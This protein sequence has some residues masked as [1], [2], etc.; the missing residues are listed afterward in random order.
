MPGATL[1]TRWIGPRSGV[2][3]LA[4]KVGFWTLLT[5]GFYRFWG[6]TRMR[7][8]FWSSVQPGGHPLEYVGHPL[9]KLLGFLIAVVIMAFYLGIV[10]LIL[11]FASYSLFS[12][13][14]GGYVASFIGVVPVIFYAQYRARRYVLARTRWRG[15]RFG[16]E[17][18]A[19]AYAWCA[20]KHWLA[21][22]LTVG[23]W[24]PR[25][26]LALETF[27]TNRTHFG[28]ARFQQSGYWGDLYRGFV[29]VIFGAFL[30]AIGIG[31]ISLGE[32]RLWPLPIAGLVWFVYG[33]LHYQAY[34]TRYLTNHKI[35]LV[36]GKAVL[37]KSDLR[38]PRVVG[39]YSLG[40]TIASG[41]AFL[42]L[43]ALSIAIAVFFVT[44]EVDDVDF[45]TT[46]VLEDVPSVVVAAFGVI[47][48]LGMMLMWNVLTYTFVTMPLWRHL[49]E[50]FSL[51]K[52]GALENVG[53]RARDEF[54]EA[55]GFAEALDVG[56]AL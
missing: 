50:T 48:Y 34:A 56:A 18:G 53:Q 19:W 5:L 38:I 40:Y 33:T 17:P 3:W 44:M 41:L 46:S 8:W 55:E 54:G 7:R 24:W 51:N 43:I 11:M 26:T 1:E 13:P 25:K 6:K 29:H 12:A 2:F 14:T 52:A 45:M 47:F 42:P 22:I 27:K 9:E 21:T 31:L 30:T 36:E 37:L 4:L 49:A 35:L 23:L 39:V 28:D 16:L 15:V 10:N 20:A 32:D